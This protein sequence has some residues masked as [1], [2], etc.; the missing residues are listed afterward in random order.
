MLEGILEQFEDVDILKADGFDDAI[1]G[2]ATDFMEPR[3]V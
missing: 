1:I 2:I 3:L